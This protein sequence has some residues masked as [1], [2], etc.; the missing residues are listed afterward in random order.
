MFMKNFLI[1]HFFQCER[2]VHSIL[3]M[4]G[5]DP[6][7]FLNML[8]EVDSLCKSCHCKLSESY[9]LIC[10][11]HLF[12]GLEQS[13]IIS[14]TPLE[15]CSKRDEQ[16]ELSTN[17]EMDMKSHLSIPRP[18]EIEL[19]SS[20]FCVDHSLHSTKQDLHES[21]LVDETI[22]K[23]RRH[24][25]SIKE[26][27]QKITVSSSIAAANGSDFKI[28]NGD[29]FF[30]ASTKGLSLEKS[31]KDTLIAKDLIANDSYIG[32]T[33]TVVVEEVLT[34]EKFYLSFASNEEK[35]S[36]QR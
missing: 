15:N 24:P 3:S 9:N 7:S 17:R 2:D 29:K 36:V 11:S 28:Q 5:E 21:T 16:V 27:Q 19:Q 22:S 6:V 18:F 34:P 1:V 31:N 30:S 13:A 20:S 32:K 35:L 4:S 33:F 25:L 10:E 23:S 12:H 26:T 8:P 14:V